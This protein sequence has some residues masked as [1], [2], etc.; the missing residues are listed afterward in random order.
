MTTID[1]ARSFLTFRIDVLKKP[2]QTV[3]HKPPYSLNNARIQIESRCEITDKSTGTAQEFLLGA[4]CKTER[5]GV[6]QDIWTVP[7]ADFVP[8]FSRDRFLNLKT[9]D[10][11]GREQ[12]VVFYP[13]Q[14]GV[15]PDRQTGVVADT[16]DTVRLDLVRCPGEQL[17]SA[18]QVV[19]ATLAN[20]PL[21]VR[22]EWETPRYAVV[23]EFPVKTMNANE[24]DNVYQTD[25]GPV[26]FP[27]LDREPA[28]LIAGFNL[29][30]AALNCPTWTDFLVRVPT[31]VA[32]GVHVYHYSRSVKL[33]TRNTLWRPEGKRS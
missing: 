21:V 19:A 20:D 16:F 24:R 22:T 13:P 14:R 23:L 12:E 11:I 17:E 25:T 32:A 10:R 15:Q 3:S 2:P 8:I 1:F 9:Y 7:N 33:A 5:V 27:D 31:D 30:F 28:D 18:E 4:S 29:A 6:E 26:L